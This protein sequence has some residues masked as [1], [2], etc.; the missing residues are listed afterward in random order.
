MRNNFLIFTPLEMMM[1]SNALVTCKLAQP[2]LGRLF[3]S[4]PLLR[5]IFFFLLNFL[6]TAETMCGPLQT[7]PSKKNGLVFANDVLL[8]C[9]Q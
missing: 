6:H 4:F 7:L 5:E 8:R 3:D 9:V 1:K 2:A